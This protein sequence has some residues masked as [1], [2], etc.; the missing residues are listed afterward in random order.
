AHEPTAEEVLRFVRLNPN[1][2]SKHEVKEYGAYYLARAYIPSDTTFDF[3]E[4]YI[5]HL[6][7]EDNPDDRFATLKDLVH[8]WVGIIKTDADNQEALVEKLWPLIALLTEEKRID[9]G[10]GFRLENYGE[11]E[12]ARFNAVMNNHEQRINHLE[13]NP[14]LKKGISK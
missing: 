12:S 4:K 2:F 13:N 10:K 6:R 14:I 8:R 11:S 3:G 5:S 9:E 7:L 1:L